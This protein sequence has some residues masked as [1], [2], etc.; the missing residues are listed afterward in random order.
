[1]YDFILL[2]IIWVVVFVNSTKVINSQAK[3]KKINPYLIS[4]GIIC[5]IIAIITFAF[6]NMQDIVSNVFSVGNIKIALSETNYPGNT[7]SAVTNLL[8]NSEVP[9]NPRITNVGINDAYV[10]LRVSVP[11]RNVTLVSDDGT[12]GTASYQEVFDIDFH[13]STNHWINLDSKKTVTNE[14]NVYVF[15]YDA[16]ISPG[17][18]TDELFTKAVFKN[19]YGDIRSGDLLDVSVEALAI[20]S[21]YVA[22]NLG[23]TEEEKKDS[24]TAIYNKFSN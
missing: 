2:K 11:V 15:G 3:K 5:L 21:E 4:A 16:K 20:Q 9:K 10:F 7:N 13:D 22:D 17:D 14:K 1:M 24:L 19:V 8:P 12:K 18:T 23:T 6:L